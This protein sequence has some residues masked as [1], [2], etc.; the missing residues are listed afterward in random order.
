[1]KFIALPND[2]LLSFYLSAEEY[3]ARQT[4]L[5]ED[6]LLLW[7]VAPT[8]IFGKHQI[9][10]QEINLP[11]CQ[12]HH[13]HI[14]QRHSGGGC[15][16]A[17]EGNLM[18]SLISPDTHSQEVFQNYLQTIA[19][20]LQHL[21]LPTATTANNDILVDEQK[22]SGN[23]CWSLPNATI[24]H[25]TLLYNVNLD[26]LTNA[27]KPSAEKLQKHSIQSV[28]QRVCNLKDL[29]PNIHSLHDLQAFFVQ[30]LCDKY[31]SLS[32][33]DIQEIEKIEQQYTKW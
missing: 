9:A 15:V 1:M 22:V 2:R 14:F 28:R 25:G 3:I 12:E 4:V 20:Q 16:Y 19:K 24:V 26:R 13:I 32:S 8:V 6:V 7:S 23:A 29:L 10:E 30:N 21:G 33:H 27:L 18:I 5:E 11:Y 31:D 17:D